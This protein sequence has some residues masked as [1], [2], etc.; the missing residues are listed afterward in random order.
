M[1]TAGH[2]NVGHPKR[3]VVR[4]G[5]PSAGGSSASGRAPKG[6]GLLGVIGSVT[7]GHPFSGSMEIQASRSD[8]VFC[9]SHHM[10]FPLPPLR[11]L[12]SPNVRSPDRSL[13]S[14]IAWIVAFRWVAKALDW[15]ST[16]Y[17]ARIL[18]P[19]DYGVVPPIPSD[20]PGA[21]DGGLG[22]RGPLSRPHLVR[23]IAQ[24]KRMTNV[25]ARLARD[26]GASSA[27]GDTRGAACGGAASYA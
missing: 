21:A 9:Y 22:A 24:A 18:I 12:P 13:V 11:T 1:S 19:A 2:P 7:R 15:A 10:S 20:R 5:Y 25:K 26:E 4:R 16:L 27:G 23:R 17:V 8:P 3:A 14:G 6:G